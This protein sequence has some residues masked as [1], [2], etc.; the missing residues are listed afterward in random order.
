MVSDAEDPVS[1]LVV[2]EGSCMSNSG[3]GSAPTST[4]TES[5]TCVHS[6]TSS[7][8]KEGEAGTLALVSSRVSTFRWLFLVFFAWQSV[9]LC[10]CVYFLAD[11][12]QVEESIGLSP[13]VLSLVWL[14]ACLIV[15]GVFALYDRQVQLLM[16][17]LQTTAFQDKV[18]A[19]DTQAEL[20]ALLVEDD[21]ADLEL[22]GAVHD[23]R[24][25][26]NLEQ[27]PNSNSGHASTA[28]LSS[29]KKQ[30]SGRSLVTLPKSQIKSFLKNPLLHQQ[31]VQRNQ[32]SISNA[33][34]YDSIADF[35][36]HA[37]VLLANIAGFGPWTSTRPPADVFYL[38]QQVTEA[39][40]RIAKRRRVTTVESDASFFAV[41]GVPDV[42]SDH[43]LRMI[44]FAQALVRQFVQVV[45]RHELALVLGPDTGDLRL[46]VGIHSGPVTAGLLQGDIVVRP[47]FQLLHAGSDTLEI[48]QTMVTTADPNRIQVSQATAELVLSSQ[49]HEHQGIWLQPRHD[50]VTTSRQSRVKAIQTY[51]LGHRATDEGSSHGSFSSRHDDG[52]GGEEGQQQQQQADGLLGVA[53]LSRIKKRR[54]NI[55]WMVELLAQRLKALMAQQQRDASNKGA[56]TTNTNNKQGMK[57][58]RSKSKVNDQLNDNTTSILLDQQEEQL[59]LDKLLDNP[60]DAI[61]NKGETLLDELVECFTP[62]ANN[63]NASDDSSLPIDPE[64]IQ[65]SQAVMQ[66][67]QSLVTKIADRYKDNCFHNFAHACHVSLS[68]NKILNRVVHPDASRG[69]A[70]IPA[71]GSAEFSLGDVHNFTHGITEDKLAHFAIVWCAL[72]HDVDHR[73]V[74][75]VRLAEENPAMGEQYK[76]RSIA[77]QNSVDIAWDLFMDPEYRDLQKCIFTNAFELNRFRQIVCN[78][79]LATDI[80]EKQAKE[81]RNQRWENA[82]RA[83]TF[84]EEELEFKERSSTLKKTI[85]IEHIIQASDVSHC[86]QHWS[87]YTKWNENLFREMFEAFDQGRS[88]NDPT[89]GWY[90]GELWFFDNYIIPL[91]KKLHECQVFG[92]SSDEFLN[93]AESNRRDWE[94]KGEQVVQDMAERYRKRK[95]MEIGGLTNDEINSFSAKDLELIMKKLI[96]RGRSNVNASVDPTKSRN[97][98]TQAWMDALEIY[99][100]AP[101]APEIRDRSIVFPVYSGIYSWLKG[102]NV[103]NDENGYFVQNLARKYTRETKLFYRQNPI[104]FFRALPMLAEVTAGIQDYETALKLIEPLKDY[105]LPQEHSR[106]MEKVYGVDRSAVAFSNAAMW[107]EQLGNTKEAFA[108]VDYVIDS[109]LPRMDPKNTLGMFELLTPLFRVLKPHG[110]SKRCYDLFNEHVRTALFRNHGPDAFTPTKSIHD[111]ILWLF[112]MSHNADAFEEFDQV[113]E[114]LTKDEDSGIVFPFLDTIVCKTTVSPST[115]NAEL[116]HL[117]IQRLERENADTEICKQIAKKSLRLVRVADK[118]IKD[119]D[120]TVLWPIANAYHEPLLKESEA[121]AKKYGV[122]FEDLDA[123]VDSSGLSISL[124]P[125]YL[126]KP[127]DAKEFLSWESTL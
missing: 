22:G 122:F 54:K 90:K 5:H 92:V 118:I 20:T 116:C 111:P 117:V 72:I 64:S 126:V 120:G 55:D 45:K 1:R 57:K 33:G 17:K 106:A 97:A 104:H 47:R 123:K 103:N 13:I 59:L 43:A 107:H 98:A 75:N 51:W 93:Y 37:T 16:G 66:Q 3:T 52:W 99:E 29:A 127:V 27:A 6:N 26:S 24:G 38:L 110:Q 88:A 89:K 40:E 58:T 105:Y 56:E 112:G 70:D 62:P 113:V 53:S 69:N 79:V 23:N 102:C 78:V 115:M 95:E 114:Y 31:K 96:E 42:Q 87:V 9:L 91:A 80:F 124:P 12:A 7:K 4:H 101:A 85:V 19:F 121:L 21:D 77:E 67:L 15:A 35:F 60:N 73:G 94:L 81:M 76:N 2:D 36:P 34:K 108:A 74:S 68:V 46:Q 86:M 44:Q 65:L 71:F 8:P 63:K 119:T 18:Q 84:E 83:K 50:M 28:L 39:F 100:R 32:K 61:E 82:F 125:S 10:I 49:E 14:V 109:V 11:A 48:C 30:R 41:T 25:S